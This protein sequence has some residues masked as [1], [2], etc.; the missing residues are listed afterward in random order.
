MIMLYSKEVNRLIIVLNPMEMNVVL[1]VR[2]LSRY[3]SCRLLPLISSLILG[4]HFGERN[5]KLTVTC[6]NSACGNFHFY[7]QSEFAVW[8][9]E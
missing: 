8:V 6:F 1:V 5:S 4:S 2:K 9:A 3:R 7:P